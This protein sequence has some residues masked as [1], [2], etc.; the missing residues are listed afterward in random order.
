MSIKR[1]KIF[2]L[3]GLDPRGSNFYHGLYR[4]EAAKF[5]KLTQNN[6][7]VLN[8]KHISPIETAWSIERSG[9]KTDYSFLRWDDLIREHWEKAFWPLCVKSFKAY[10]GIIT[11]YDWKTALKVQIKPLITI[12]SPII[13]LIALIWLVLK[14]WDIAAAISSWWI[15]Q[16]PLLALVIWGAAKAYS[17]LN[18]PWLLR[19]FAINNDLM[20]N[21]LPA[22]WGR[23]EDFA[24]IINEALDDKTYDEVVLIS[25]SYGGVMLFPTLSYLSEMR[26]NCEGLTIVTLGQCSPTASLYQTPPYIAHVKKA[27]RLNINWH[28]IAA[29]ADAIC[30]SLVGPYKPIG[31]INDSDVKNTITLRSPRFHTMYEEEHYKRLRWNKYAYHFLYLTCPDHAPKNN[32]NYFDLTTSDQ[33][34]ADYIANLKG[35]V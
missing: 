27:A 3:P 1:R 23:S 33:P 16:L 29:P 21:K 5:E 7:N 26:E 2:Y 17:K 9:V 18:S 13:F 15:I 24:G 32:Y 11:N 4:D 34:C 30:W 35:S 20:Q 25:H 6:I 28:D 10:I 12:F 22:F 31:A 14:G 8:R 19:S